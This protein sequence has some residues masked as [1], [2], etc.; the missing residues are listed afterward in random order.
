[1]LKLTAT[2][3]ITT[4]PQHVVDEAKELAE[5]SAA[6][7]AKLVDLKKSPYHQNTVHSH[8]IGK[9]GEIGAALAFEQLKSLARANIIVEEV[10][11]DAKRDAECDLVINEMRIEVKCWKP[12]AIELYGP[13]ISDRQAKKLGKKCD[14]VVYCTFDERSKQFELIGWNTIEDIDNTPSQLTGPKNSPAKMV[15]NRVMKA[16]M[17]TELPILT[18]HAA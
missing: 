8:F 11:R 12:Y 13:C 3:I 9:M 15:L 7:Y 16:R 14:A 1:M 6:K 10:F 18:H 5:S 17:I 4:I 2:S